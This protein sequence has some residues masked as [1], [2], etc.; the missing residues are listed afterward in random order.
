MEKCQIDLN[1]TQNSQDTEPDSDDEMNMLQS[2][3]E[4]IRMEII[5]LLFVVLNSSDPQLCLE[6]RENLAIVSL[7]LVLKE[8]SNSNMK[9]LR[10]CLNILIAVTGSLSCEL[11]SKLV[12]Q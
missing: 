2:E 8:M 3:A 9:S 7:S 5:E 4:P 6:E 10:T 12:N 1:A 11:T